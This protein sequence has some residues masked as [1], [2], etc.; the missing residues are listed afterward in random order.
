MN[1]GS[2]LKIIQKTVGAFSI[3]LEGK[4]RRE[5]KQCKYI[6][7]SAIYT[8]KNYH[9]RDFPGGPVVKNPP[10][11]AGEVGHIPDW[12]TRFPHALGQLSPCATTTELTHLN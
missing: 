3:F 9:T 2:Y 4:K 7:C 12:V 6:I 1:H 10:S 11:K 5:T 8:L